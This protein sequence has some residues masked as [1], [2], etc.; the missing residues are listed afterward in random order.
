MLSMYPF[1]LELCANTDQTS[2]LGLGR[3][4]GHDTGIHRAEGILADQ[5]SFVGSGLWRFREKDWQASP[6]T[7]VLTVPVK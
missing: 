3:A 1:I 4:V 7:K 6:N 2:C 5:F